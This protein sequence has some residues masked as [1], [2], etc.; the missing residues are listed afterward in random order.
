[1]HTV[2][3]KDSFSTC[4][5]FTILHA[6]YLASH[7]HTH[8]A[9]NVR[10][11]ICSWWLDQWRDQLFF[12]FLFSHPEEIEMQ[13]V[14]IDLRELSDLVGKKAVSVLDLQMWYCQSNSHNSNT[15]LD[16]LNTNRCCKGKAPG[17]RLRVGQPPSCFTAHTCKSLWC[18][19]KPLYGVL[20][21]KF[22]VTKHSVSNTNTF[23]FVGFPEYRQRVQ[24]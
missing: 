2:T 10:I 20:N 7:T 9:Y 3:V 13:C 22:R 24:I 21:T 16:N 6:W 19:S 5:G 14:F 17:Q 23:C 12:Y 18:H 8:T 11:E 1:M 4:V 15:V